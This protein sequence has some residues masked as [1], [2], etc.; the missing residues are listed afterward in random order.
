MKRKPVPH[1]LL[2]TFLSYVFQIAKIDWNKLETTL[3][4]H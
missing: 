4:P 1:D 3:S 2:I